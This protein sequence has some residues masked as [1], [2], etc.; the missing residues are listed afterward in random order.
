MQYWALLVKLHSA[1]KFMQATHV[2]LRG[3]GRLGSAGQDIQSAEGQ[4]IH[5]YITHARQHNHTRSNTTTCQ[6]HNM[7]TARQQFVDGQAN[8]SWTAGPIVRGWLGQQFVGSQATITGWLGQ[9]FLDSQVTIRGRL[10]NNSW[11]ASQQF[12]DGQATIRGQLSQNSWTPRQFI[13]GL[14]VCA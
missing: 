1:G 14:A 10:G 7:W 3:L 6:L 8:N 11:V 9:Q 2:G 13:P 5:V 12:I 4:A